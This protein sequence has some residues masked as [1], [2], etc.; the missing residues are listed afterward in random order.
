[1]MARS[2]R[3]CASPLAVREGVRHGALGTRHVARGPVALQRD[4]HA[5]AQGNQVLLAAL[6]VA[7]HLTDDQFRVTQNRDAVDLEPPQ[8]L[9]AEQERAVFRDVIRRG[10]VRHVAP[11]RPH[12]GAV[13]VEHRSQ[14]RGPRVASTAA[15][16][17]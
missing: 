16:K 3:S 6:P 5:V 2:C 9:A 14:A 15:V 8:R 11:A 13:L 4:P 17:S 7:L 1:M 10:R 12:G